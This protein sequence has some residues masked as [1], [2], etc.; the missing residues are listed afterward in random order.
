MNF[1]D[2][3]RWLLICEGLRLKPYLDT[4]KKWTI[5]VGRNLEARKITKDEADYLTS[6]DKDKSRV[7]SLSKKWYRN[8]DEIVEYL[9]KRE[10]SPEEAEY[11]LKNDIKNCI[12]SL[13]KHDFYISAPA[14]LKC[15]LINMAFQMGV[16]GL[17][18]FRKMIKYL[19]EKNYSKAASEALDSEWGR[20]FVK[21]SKDVA[22]IIKSADK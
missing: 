12:D 16:S 17:L 22:D 18:K 6:R 3:P 11:I 5:G 14:P 15:A 4:K 13:I 19:N 20:E 9:K 1:D 10:L 7:E 2:L 8:T 21:R